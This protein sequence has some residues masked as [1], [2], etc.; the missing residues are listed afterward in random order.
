[1]SQYIEEQQLLDHMTLV[2]DAVAL[3]GFLMSLGADRLVKPTILAFVN[4]HGMNLAAQDLAFMRD[5]MASDLVLRDGSGIKILFKL[6]GRAPGLNLNGT[7]LIPR[8]LELYKGQSLALL[9]TQSPYLERAADVIKAHGGVIGVQKDGFQDDAIYLTLAREA[10]PALIIL[11]M[12]MPKQERVARLLAQGLEHPCLIVCGGAI[13]DF[14]GGKVSR[15]PKIFRSLG[16]EWAY[17]LMLEPRR[18]FKRYVIGNFVFLWR[19]ILMT[20]A[21]KRAS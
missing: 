2:H 4:A 12:G 20:L 7:D 15:A 18:L 1:M 14:M 21:V 10:K 8:I 16:L 6:L 3:D 17:R 5:L 13:L 9:G 11:A 19:G